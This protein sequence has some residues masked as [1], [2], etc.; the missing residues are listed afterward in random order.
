M[1]IPEIGAGCRMTQKE[2]MIAYRAA[3]GGMDI[4]QLEAEYRAA[5]EAAGR[6]TNRD[7][8]SR[9]LW[10]I[11]LRSELVRRGELK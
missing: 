1:C 9:Y 8:V 11:A 7:C 2:M 5:R 3:A 4:D 6:A 10:S